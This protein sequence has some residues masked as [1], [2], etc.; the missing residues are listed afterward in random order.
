[1]HLLGMLQ[2]CSQAAYID[3]ITEEG[4][5]PEVAAYLKR[6]HVL[7]SEQGD[8]LIRSTASNPDF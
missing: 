6:E 2:Y 4:Q 8:L 1:M 5:V 7:D 3:G